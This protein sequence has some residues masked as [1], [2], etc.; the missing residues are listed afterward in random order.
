MRSALFWLI[1]A[2][3][4]FLVTAGAFLVLANFGIAPKAND[5]IP[6]TG[7]SDRG[8]SG[9]ELALKFSEER[10][11]GLEKRPNQTLTLYLENRGDED[12]GNVDLEVTVS[13]E[14][15]ARPWTRRYRKTVAG[16]APGEM[17]AVD[18]NVDLSPAPSV[19]GVAVLDDSPGGDRQ[20][21]EAKAYPS[22]G[23]VVVVET[24]V[25]SP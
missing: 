4:A 18:L 17:A 8:P 12:L 23:A 9:P 22:G 14:D 11:E 1:G 2:S 21:L 10:L 15:T 19:K 13:T 24:A 6:R 7:P 16:L 20:I 25:L 3:L 5:P